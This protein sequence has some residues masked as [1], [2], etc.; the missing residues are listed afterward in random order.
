MRDILN[1]SFIIVGNEKYKTGYIGE[2]YYVRTVLT[3]KGWHIF[4]RPNLIN[5]IKL[6]IG[7]FFSKW[8]FITDTCYNLLRLVGNIS[9]RLLTLFLLVN[10]LI[11]HLF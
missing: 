2:E 5:D 9:H 4:F 11:G 3:T 8:H 1:M 6:F 10:F 7:V